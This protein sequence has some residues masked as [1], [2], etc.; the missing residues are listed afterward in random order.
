MRGGFKPTSEPR[1]ALSLLDV[2]DLLS[3]TSNGLV[4]AAD[5]VLASR[6]AEKE[7]VEATVV[8]HS[9]LRDE[10]SPNQLLTIHANSLMSGMPDTVTK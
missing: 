2:N 3:I 6:P 9:Q 1:E 5:S 4:W 10:I 8:L 7:T